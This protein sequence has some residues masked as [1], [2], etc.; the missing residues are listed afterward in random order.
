MLY[1]LLPSPDI[2]LSPLFSRRPESAYR[3]GSPCH[4]LTIRK[5]AAVTL[6]NGMYIDG[7][8]DLQGVGDHGVEIVARNVEG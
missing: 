8:E 4:N 1:L 7:G 5:G 6:S 2:S 3:R